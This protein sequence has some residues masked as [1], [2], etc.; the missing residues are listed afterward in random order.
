MLEKVI[1]ILSE[2]TDIPAEKITGESRL[3]GDLD[4]SS[5][6]LVGLLV[7]FEK[8]F[9]VS[10]DEAQAVEFQTVNDVVRF[11]ESIPETNGPESENK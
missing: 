6:E 4:L 1:K 11:L 7:E 5:I 8:E 10:I 2:Y 3:T 9:S